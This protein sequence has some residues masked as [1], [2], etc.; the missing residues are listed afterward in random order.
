MRELFVYYR[1]DPP[2]SDAARVAVAAMQE[3]LRRR[4]RGLVARLLVRAEDGATART[5][6]EVYALP[7]SADG[8][9]R[10]LE[11]AIEAEAETWASLRSGPRHV[12]AFT[13]SS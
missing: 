4:H 9:D 5:W 3:R 12:E 13:L 10:R 1:V 7:G 8:V 11:A 6:M 2:D